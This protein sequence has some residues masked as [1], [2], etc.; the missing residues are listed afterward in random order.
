MIYGNHIFVTFIVSK[1]EMN[2]YRMQIIMV[3]Q[4]G[5]III[6]SGLGTVYRPLVFFYK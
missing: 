4:T 5:F 1:S 6:L 3:L 2:G